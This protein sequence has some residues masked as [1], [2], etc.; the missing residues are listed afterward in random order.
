MDVKQSLIARVDAVRRG[1]TIVS[2][3]TSG[4]PIASLAAGRTADFR[5]H[6]LGTH[7]FNPPRY[8]RLV[9]VIPTPDTESAVLA[10][11]SAFVD[12]DL[13]K[14][15]VVAKDTPNFIANHIALFGVVQ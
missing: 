13:G 2:S 5:R 8:L 6:W 9:E 12:H 7:F 10:R 3:N 1:A 4:I 15:V 11:I 14:G